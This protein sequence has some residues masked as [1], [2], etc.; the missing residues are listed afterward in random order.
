MSI[1]QAIAL[2]TIMESECVK[3]CEME[4]VSGVN[5]LDFNAPGVIEPDRPRRGEKLN[6]E[7]IRYGQIVKFDVSAISI[8]IADIRKY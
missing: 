7:T 5:P 4:L 8:A 1:F 3:N 2:N 6:A